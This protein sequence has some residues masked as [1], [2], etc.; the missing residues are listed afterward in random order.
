MIFLSTSLLKNKHSIDILTSLRHFV[1]IDDHIEVI[2][3]GLTFEYDAFVIFV[4]SR[5]ESYSLKDIEALLLAHQE[6]RI[7]NLDFPTLSVN[8]AT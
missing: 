2:F 6:A 5:F 1:F 4:S 8:L 7:E 3:N